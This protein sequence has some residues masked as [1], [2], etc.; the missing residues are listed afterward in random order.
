LTTNT[1]PNAAIA[2]KTTESR[3][4]GMLCQRDGTAS[5]KKNAPTTI[6]GTK[7]VAKACRAR[8]RL[9]AR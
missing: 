7:R 6:G 2:A 4:S 3:K 8:P 5:G 1:Q 9:P